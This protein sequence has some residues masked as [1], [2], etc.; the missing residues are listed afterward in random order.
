MFMSFLRSWKV[1]FFVEFARC[2]RLFF[3]SCRCEQGCDDGTARE[4]GQAEE[5]KWRA[6]TSKDLLIDYE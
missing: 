2:R 1:H 5:A 4:V 6:E 3:S